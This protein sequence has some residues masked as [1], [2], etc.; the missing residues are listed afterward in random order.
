MANPFEDTFL[1][2]IFQIERI[3]DRFAGHYCEQNPSIFGE[4]DTCFLLCYGIIMLNTDLHNPAVKQKTSQA[5]FIRRY[6]EL[7]PGKALDTGFLV[8]DAHCSN[9]MVGM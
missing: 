7:D 4:N 6:K 8:S 1:R 3:M 2:F 9:P 5:D